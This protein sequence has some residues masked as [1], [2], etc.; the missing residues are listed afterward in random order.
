MIRKN[1]LVFVKKNTR[2]RHSFPKAQKG[3]QYLVTNYYTNN[4]GTIKYILIDREG[5]EYFTTDACVRKVL[6]FCLK[7]DEEWQSAKILWMDRTYVPVFGVHT[8]DY[9][10]MPYV[11]SR[12]GKSRLIKPLA[13]TKKDGVWI[14]SSVVHD[15]DVKTFL[16][17]SFPPDSSKKGKLSEAVTFRI[18]M[19][20][21]ERNGF[22]DVNKS[23]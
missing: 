2:G 16:S 7:D 23:K 10:G 14:N 22:F 3:N 20:I 1:D 17:S 4:M 15:N 12:D 11:S 13:N 21:A 19:W 6:D 18:P 9:V 5:L 8:Y